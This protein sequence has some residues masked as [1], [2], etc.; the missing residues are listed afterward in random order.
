MSSQGNG[1]F[2]QGRV[3]NRPPFFVETLFLLA[4]S[5]ANLFY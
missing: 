2:A 4:F 5:Q 3:S 1:C